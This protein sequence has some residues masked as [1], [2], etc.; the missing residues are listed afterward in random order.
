M[1]K[2]E[3]KINQ[4]NRKK[5]LELRNY[6]KLLDRNDVAELKAMLLHALDNH[7]IGYSLSNEIYVVT[8]QK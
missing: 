2:L 7:N 6:V 3:T 1:K 5:L 4:Q 8:F